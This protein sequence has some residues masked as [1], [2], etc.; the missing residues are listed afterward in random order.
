MMCQWPALIATLL[1]LSSPLRAQSASSPWKL[2]GLGVD[3]AQLHQLQQNYPEI[4][5]EEDLSQLLN[6]LSQIYPTADM[7]PR[8]N[9]LEWIITLERQPILD[10]L[11]FEALGGPLPS[12]LPRGLDYLVG[13]VYSPLMVEKIRGTALDVL[14]KEGYY[15]A[16]TKIT[17][18]RE[19]DK[20]TL[21]LQ[22]TMGP[23][24]II[25]SVTADF[26]LPEKAEELLGAHCR[27]VIL[28]RFITELK[29][30]YSGESYVENTLKRGGV[31]YDKQ[32]KEATFH[33][34][35]VPGPRISYKFSLHPQAV[36]D[37]KLSE[38][39]SDLED[40][41]TPENYS[42]YL[43]VGR[44]KEILDGEDYIFAEIKDPQVISEDEQN[45]VYAF[46]IHPASKVELGSLRVWEVKALPLKQIYD[47]LGTSRWW[48]LRRRRIEIGRLEERILSLENLYRD[49]G[50]W[51]IRIFQPKTS[52]RATTGKT[53]V[54]L[55]IEEG[56]RYFFRSISFQGARALSSE[57]LSEIWHLE[58][59]TP[60]KQSEMLEMRRET[61]ALYQSLGYVDVEV[62]LN[63]KRVLQ[64]G[65]YQT[66][67]A[68][69]VREGSKS[70]MGEIFL[71]GLSR[72]RREVVMRELSFVSGESYSLEKIRQTHR[73][74]TALGLF[75]SVRLVPSTRQTGSDSKELIQD[76]S[77]IVR[78]AR[79]G[80]ISYGP[81][82]DFFHG[83]NY[84]IEA[85]YENLFGMGRRLFARLKVDEA[86][87]QALIRERTLL[88]THLSL[89]YVH[90]YLVGAPLD[91]LLSAS[92]RAVPAHYWQ[93]STSMNQSLRYRF[94]DRR[95]TS[96]SFFSEQ[97]LQ[98]EVGSPEQL[99]YYLALGDVRIF[100]AGSSLSFDLSD[101][102]LWPARGSR[103]EFTYERAFPVRVL[104][105][106]TEYHKLDLSSLYY[107][108]LWRKDVVLA[109]GVRWTTIWD[110]ARRGTATRNQTLPLSKMLLAGGSDLVRGFPQ[111][112]GPYVHYYR[113]NSSGVVESTKD[114][115]GGTTRLI[116]KPR[117]RFLFSESFAV[118]LFYDM[119]S[120]YLSQE[121]LRRFEERFAYI[122]PRRSQRPH[123]Y[124]N[125]VVNWQD[126]QHPLEF[127][128]RFYSSSGISL[129]YLTPIGR[130]RL[131]AAYPLHQPGGG[132]GGC[133]VEDSHCWDRRNKA[134]P[135]I[136]RLKFDL[137]VA[138]RF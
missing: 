106:H 86:R 45:K 61:V 53:D 66:D 76:I 8:F 138:G 5:S 50:Y 60:L 17:A 65:S 131:S 122:E 42:P 35:G 31:K 119:G 27:Q 93:F 136:G 18:K 14:K 28:D 49:L 77:I 30:Q 123:I 95:Q 120:S 82:Y 104:D 13:Q 62:L 118:N 58:A 1:L 130:L 89:G 92:H 9:G 36:A 80:S 78:E 47:E 44:L 133:V 39:I 72:V 7:Q 115:I 19:E 15:E 102:R 55:R 56:E 137:T 91:L 107:Y 29:K 100:T 98:S 99:T 25:H 48:S 75:Q 20:V 26:P 43:A 74:L 132:G 40:D 4:S 116:F 21:N 135:V 84:N 10:D 52:Y 126:L 37:E 134:L 6:A 46:I 128:S 109:L 97:S 87:S 73:N 112:L 41:L 121:I 90:P 125:V 32:S 54:T 63:F 114:I 34:A 33:I 117:V 51:D 38:I 64:Q 94:A 69:E 83:Y 22:V 96:L 23:R 71:F 2:Q 70:V 111:Q 127:W 59:Q 79:H 105:F 3:R 81:G 101:D 12:G 103:W 57:Q 124:E 88:G 24:C 108:S 16:R 129:D 68:V 110:V 113:Q 85:S 67:I 11:R